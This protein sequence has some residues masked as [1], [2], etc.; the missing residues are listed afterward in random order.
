MKIIIDSRERSNFSI[1]KVLNEKKMEWCVKKLEYGDYSFEING[2]SYEKKCVVERKM[3][4]TEL[5]GNICQGRNRFEIEFCKGKADNCEMTLLIE[6]LKA[7]EKMKLRAQMDASGI[8]WDTK[9]RK[10]W[11]TKCTGNSMIGSIKALRDR[12]NLNLVFCSKV[13]TA[14]E[15]LRIFEEYLIKNRESI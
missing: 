8:D 12:Y 11:R 9:F 5:S 2:E 10:T 4:L 1:V 7:R 15:M 3:N 6:D 13:R 14:S